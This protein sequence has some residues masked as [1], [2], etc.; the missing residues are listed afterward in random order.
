MADINDIEK[1]IQLRFDYFATENFEITDENEKLIKKQLIDYF[2]EHINRDFFVA[3]VEDE[4]GNILSCA[5]LVIN[6]KPAN[7]NFPTGKTGLLLNVLTYSGHRLQGY[8]RNNIE[9]L[10]LI[11]KSQNLSYIE[12]SSSEMGK[13]L[14]QKLGFSEPQVSHFTS[15]KLNLL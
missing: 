14:Y 8:A 5:F 1:L 15:M 3:L 9:K 6:D 2:P 7:S 10:I 12:L 13:P 4:K 11:A